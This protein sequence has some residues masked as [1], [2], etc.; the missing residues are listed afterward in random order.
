MI[1]IWCKHVAAMYNKGVLWPGVR[2]V[3]DIAT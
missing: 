3:S 2:F 1:G